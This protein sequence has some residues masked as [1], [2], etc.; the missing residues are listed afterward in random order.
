M[1]SSC[2]T[3]SH[4][5]FFSLVASIAE[6]SGGTLIPNWVPVVRAVEQ[7]GKA[8]KKSLEIRSDWY[9]LC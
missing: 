8:V 9:I 1:M 4:K 2:L 6:L 7:E 3:T 5:R